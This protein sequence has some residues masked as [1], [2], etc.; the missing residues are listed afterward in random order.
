MKSVF[1]T[2]AA[3]GIGLATAR[4]FA[5]NGWKVGLFDIDSD[6]LK[7]LLSEPEFSSAC[8]GYC[9]VTNLKSVSEAMSIFS[10]HCSGE[11]HALINNAGVLFS[12]DFSEM[13]SERIDS[14]IEVNIGG[15]TR[16]AH[17]A[18]PFLKQTSNSVMVN[19]C[20]ASS[21]YGIPAIAVYSASKFYVRGLTEALNIEWARHD[22]HVCSLKPPY[23]KTAMFD[24][25]PSEAKKKSPAEYSPQQIAEMIFE[26]TSNKKVATLVGAKVKIWDWIVRIFPYSL[27]KPMT[28]NVSG[29]EN[30]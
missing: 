23:V 19:I 9:D 17:Q 11:M 26:A 15:M 6:Q 21:I 8:G 12:G 5:K 10:E 14:T 28:K 24:D 1:I 20:S 7:R 27:G 16:V 29:Y 4:T 18:F 30:E 2:G 3:R 22:I 25:A 13:E